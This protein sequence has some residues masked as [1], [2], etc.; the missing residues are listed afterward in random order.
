MQRGCPIKRHKIQS[1][2]GTHRLHIVLELDWWSRNNMK[3]RKENFTWFW[4]MKKHSVRYFT[5]YD[6]ICALLYKLW[7]RLITKQLSNYNWILEQNWLTHKQIHKLRV[8][9]SEEVMQ[10]LNST[11]GRFLAENLPRSARSYYSKCAVLLK[12]VLSFCWRSG[13]SCFV[14]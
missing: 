1:M 14:K 7:L 5:K 12:Y 2:K 9:L 13:K 4:F 3:T 11:I 10:I 6:Y 8:L